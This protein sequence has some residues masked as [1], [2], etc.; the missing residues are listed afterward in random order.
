MSGH[1]IKALAGWGTFVD[2]DGNTVNASTAHPAVSGRTPVGEFRVRPYGG[3][4]PGDAAGVVE[5]WTDNE[6]DTQYV[7]SNFVVLF[8][9]EC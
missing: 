3:S 4:S 8:T 1:Y 6:T 5:I 7:E 2:E 9:D